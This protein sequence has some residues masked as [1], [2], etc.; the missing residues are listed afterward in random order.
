MVNPLKWMAW[1]IVLNI[2]YLAITFYKREK[3]KNSL[4][5]L[6]NLDQEA[7]NIIN[8]QAYHPSQLAAVNPV[9]TG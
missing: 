5:N 8:E 7:A 1:T 9:P 2:E 4:P 6:I 3:P